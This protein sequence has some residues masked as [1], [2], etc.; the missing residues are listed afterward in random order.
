MKCQHL[1]HEPAILDI[2][3]AHTIFVGAVRLHTLYHVS[4]EFFE[5]FC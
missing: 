5:N 1:I 3:E 2:P 4:G